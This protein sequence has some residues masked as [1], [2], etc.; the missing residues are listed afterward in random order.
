MCGIFALMSKL[1][2]SVIQNEFEKG[3]NRGPE[4]SKLTKIN[5]LHT[6]DNNMYLGFHRLAINGLNDKSNQPL[7][8][9]GV[10]LICNGEIYNYKQLYDMMNLKGQTDSDCEVIIHLYQKYGFEQML[11]M[12][13]GVF[14][15]ILLD[16]S[17]LKDPKLFIG[18]DPYGVR[19]LYINDSKNNDETLLAVSSDLKMIT[20]LMRDD[21]KMKQNDIYLEN[22]IKHFIPGTYSYYTL[23]IDRWK[24]EVENKKYITL[25]I[26]DFTDNEMLKK[27]KY[28]DT[29]TI[30]DGDKFKL[31]LEKISKSLEVA[32]EKRVD[33]TDRPV[34]CL[35][36]G[37]LDSSLI[38]AIVNNI[39]KMKSKQRLETYSIG[40][41]DSEDLR[42]ARIVAEYLNTKHTEVVVTE[43]E[44]I[45]AIPQV[46]YE[47]ETYDTTTIRAS[48][49][50]YLVA[51]YISKNSDAKVIFNGDGADELMGGYLYF[52]KCPDTIEFDKECKRLLST[53][54]CYDVLRSDKSISSNGLE[55]RTPFLDRFFVQ[56]YLSLHPDLRNHNKIEKCEKYLIREA[57]SRKRYSNKPILPD[58]ILWRTKEAFSDGVSKKTRSWFEIINEY[59][60][61]YERVVNK[62]LVEVK[63]TTND[64]LSLEQNYYL[65][66]FNQYYAKHKQIIPFYWMPKYVDAKDSSARTLDIYQKI[67]N[68][69]NDKNIGKV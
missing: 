13:D 38:C 11:R 36:S 57:F 66:I 48:V 55:A 41:K 58:K 8:H 6:K 53:I 4:Y 65:D 23:N 47:V 24:L 31:V 32:V 49:G 27:M 51:K 37:G 52:H 7:I 67:N 63:N 45:E 17:D 9:N 40:L 69:K 3:K 39:L 25:S 19:P 33:N 30:E 12:L 54:Y 22:S 14:S 21:F 1:D 46:V 62:D 2:V 20:D 28:F 61:N 56:T 64:E 44:M 29:F 50:N 26:P 42:Y 10:F 15:I 34:A 5:L 18:R 68:E 59:L 35:L 60:D 16:N 43:K